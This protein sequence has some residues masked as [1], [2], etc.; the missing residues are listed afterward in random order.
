M[1]CSVVEHLQRLHST[2]WVLVPG[3]GDDLSLHQELR[4]DGHSSM[5]MCQGYSPRFVLRLSGRQVGMEEKAGYH[6]H[7]S[8]GRTNEV[9]WSLWKIISCAA[10]V[11]LSQDALN[12]CP[13]SIHTRHVLSAQHGELDCHSGVGVRA[14]T[15]RRPFKWFQIKMRGRDQETV[16]YVSWRTGS[17]FWESIS[18]ALG[19]L[20]RGRKS[21]KTF[22]SV[23]GC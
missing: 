1:C 5:T 23:L 8:S 17:F 2:D 4:G 11:Q 6:Q 15:W 16:F 9:R 3:S 21:K 19:G 18:P 13:V 20:C 10:E 14:V 7:R 12:D 22:Y